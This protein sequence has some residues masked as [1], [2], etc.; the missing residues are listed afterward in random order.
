MYEV[1]TCEVMY[2]RATAEDG[3]QVTDLGVRVRWPEIKQ[4]AAGLVDILYVL[5]II[6][7]QLWFSAFFAEQSTSATMANAS[8]GRDTN[9][10]VLYFISVVTAGSSALH[11]HIPAIAT[12]AKEQKSSNK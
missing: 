4:V 7:A 11:A 2:E 5:D 6:N 9:V 3:G 12:I 10:I 8:E 1:Y